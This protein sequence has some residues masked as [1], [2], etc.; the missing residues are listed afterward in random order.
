MFGVFRRQPE[1]RSSDPAPMYA[2]EPVVTAEAYNR[3]LAFMRAYG[4]T[5]TLSRADKAL[6]GRM[7]SLPV[8]WKNTLPP[9]GV[10]ANPEMAPSRFAPLPIPGTAPSLPLGAYGLSGVSPLPAAMPVPGMTMGA[11]ADVSAP[12]P[13]QGGLTW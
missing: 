6:I 3:L 5:Q 4:R 1:P 10:F 11:T 7:Q 8:S 9:A 13:A 2:N 12:D